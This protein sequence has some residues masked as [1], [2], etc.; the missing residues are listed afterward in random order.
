[1]LKKIQSQ[2]VIREKLRKTLLY[3]KGA[4]K[5]L[6]KLTPTEHAAAE[7]DDDKQEAEHACKATTVLL[8]KQPP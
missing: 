2:S 1:L 8:I 6:V 4:P 3:K 7:E 5:M